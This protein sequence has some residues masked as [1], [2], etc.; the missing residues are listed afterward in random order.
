MKDKKEEEDKSNIDVKRIT[1]K[2][3]GVAL[4]W[5]ERY[6]KKNGPVSNQFLGEVEEINEAEILT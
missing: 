2:L 1:Y 3:C 4:T 5:W 6:P